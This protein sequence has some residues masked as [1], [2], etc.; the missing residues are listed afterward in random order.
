MGALQHDSSVDG[1]VPGRRSKSLRRLSRN[2]AAGLTLIAL[3]RECPYDGAR[4]RRGHD[5]VG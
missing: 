1:Y 5:V 3:L 4:Y 2:F